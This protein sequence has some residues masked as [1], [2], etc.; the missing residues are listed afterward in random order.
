MKWN[1]L[2]GN[3]VPKVDPAYVFPAITEDVKL[4]IMEGKNVML[5][6]QTGTGKSSLIAQIAATVNQ[7]VLRANLNGQMT[8]SDFVGFYTVKG[9]E[10]IWVDGVLPKAMRDGDW[11]VLEEI[12]FAE[13]ALLSILNTVLEKDGP[14]V[15]KEKGHEIVPRHPNFRI[16]GTGNTIGAMQKFRG[17][18]QGASIMNEAFMDRWRVYLVTYLPEAQEAEMLVKTFPQL[19]SKELRGH[20]IKPIVE[21]AG[22]VREAFRKEDVS[23]TFS[24]R[25]LID[26]TEL[27]I[28]KARQLKAENKKGAAHLLAA[29]IALFSKMSEEDAEV[30]RGIINRTIDVKAGEK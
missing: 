2:G 1:G 3:F 10:T 17:L 26:W 6:G 9:A 21:I 27:T 28:R 7:N 14:L 5:T 13:P 29:D 25:R 23:T 20:V 12:D 15:L 22:L 11:L 4:D 16:F 24:T 18:Y 30:V 19:A 8:I